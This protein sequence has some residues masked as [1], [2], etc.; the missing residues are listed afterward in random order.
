MPL[1]ALRRPPASRSRRGRIF[2]SACSMISSSTSSSSSSSSSSVS[3]ALSSSS[4]LAL[5]ARCGPCSMR[6]SARCGSDAARSMLAARCGPCPVRPTA[7]CI[8]I[9]ARS[10]LAMRSVRRGAGCA[11]A[12]C[13][14]LTCRWLLR[15][16]RGSASVMPIRAS[17]CGGVRLQFVT[18]MYCHA[19]SGKDAS[20]SGMSRDPRAPGCLRSHRTVMC[21]LSSSQGCRTSPTQVRVGYLVPSM[22]GLSANTHAIRFPLW[23]FRSFASNTS[24]SISS[25]VILPRRPAS[26]PAVLAVLLSR[27]D[28]APT[29]LSVPVSF[30]SFRTPSLMTLNKLYCESEKTHRA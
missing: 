6:R 27:P 29:P 8:S 21:F 18:S 28:A 12:V 9:T 24:S 22:S 13:S 2:S 7:G 15:S 10:M 25:P 17:R 19:G 23:K 1:L 14:M 5:T 3:S 11:S 20:G 30:S 26:A 16:V 4:K